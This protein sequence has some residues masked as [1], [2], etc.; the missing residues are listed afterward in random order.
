MDIHFV[1]PQWEGNDTFSEFTHVS[2]HLEAKEVGESIARGKPFATYP[3]G[4]S[5]SGRRPTMAGAIIENLS[6][7]KLGILI[8]F[9]MICQ[10]AC[11]LVGGLIGKSRPRTRRNK[12]TRRNQPRF[13][14]LFRKNGLRVTLS[15]LT[16]WFLRVCLSS[17]G[18]VRGGRVSVFEVSE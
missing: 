18:G 4:I 14:S 16:P 17:E 13:R 12:G 5:G 3:A 9:L 8:G 6:G 1:S 2:S 10:I 7:R 11:F 15:R